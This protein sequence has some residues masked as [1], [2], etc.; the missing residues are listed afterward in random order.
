V[1]RGRRFPDGEPAAFLF[2]AVRESLKDSTGALRHGVAVAEAFTCTGFNQFNLGYIDVLEKWDILVEGMNPV[3][4]TNIA[5][6]VNPPGAPSLSMLDEM[7]FHNVFCNYGWNNPN[8]AVD[9]RNPN[10]LPEST[11]ISGLPASAGSR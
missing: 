11:P 6:Q 7:D 4:R 9:L 2:W 8:F 5:P 1:K 3:A 10:T